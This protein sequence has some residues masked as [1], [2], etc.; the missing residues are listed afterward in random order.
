LLQQS[1]RT[2]FGTYSLQIAISLDANGKLRAH[3]ESGSGDANRDF[4]IEQMLTGVDV[5]ATPPDGMKYPIRLK[6]G[7]H[8]PG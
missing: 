3:I 5:D 4:F 2:R 7:A 6:I 8:A 1:D